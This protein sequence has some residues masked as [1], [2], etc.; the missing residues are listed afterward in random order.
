[1]FGIFGHKKKLAD[2]GQV[3]IDMHS[4]LIPGID[5]GVN[6]MD[7]SLRS[8]RLLHNAGYTHLITTPHIM[9]DYFPN[10]PETI[11]SGLKQV[12]EAVKKEGIPVKI[13]AAAE[14]YLDYPF[15]EN[16]D[17]TKH[18]AIND[19]FLLFEL[20][21]LNPPEILNEII[22]RIQTAGYIPVLAHPER[23]SYWFRNF[24]QFYKLKDRGVWLQLNINSFADEYGV[25][26]R[27]L[28]EKMIKAD[29]VDLLGSD[30]HRP[31]H[32]DSMQKALGNKH[33]GKLINSGKLRNAELIS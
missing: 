9:S 7:E 28:A 13:D 2:L 31:Q 3:G 21:F 1:M 19:R 32:I 4:H 15:F 30:F 20:S 29:I 10:S 5:D 18:L 33:L 14:Y 11:I 27:K 23:Y 25:P 12:R 16:F 17:K 6:D 8:I 24:D 26:T 22:F